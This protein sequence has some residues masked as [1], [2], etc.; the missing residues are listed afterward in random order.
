MTDQEI[1][2]YTGF[3]VCE[4]GPD[5]Y[6][7]CDKCQSIGKQ[8]YWMVDGYYWCVDCVTKLALDNMAEENL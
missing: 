5:L 8:L 7:N 2:K 1:K 6:S 3:V 4:F